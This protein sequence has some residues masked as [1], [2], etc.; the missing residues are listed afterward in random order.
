MKLPEAVATLVAGHSLKALQCAQ[1]FEELLDPAT[2]DA[3]IAAFLRALRAKGE[4][5]DEIAGAAKTMLARALPVDLGAGDELLDTC[6]TGGDRIGTFNISTGAALIAAAAGVKVAKHGNRAASGRVG[7]ADVLEAL[8]VKL[9]PPIEGLRRC[10]ERAGICFLFAPKFHP[11][12][13]RLAPIRRAIGVR[14]IFNLL[15]PLCNPAQAGRRLIGVADKS[16]ARPVAEAALALDLKHLLVIH[17]DDGLDEISSNAQTTLISVRNGRLS[18]TRL[19]PRSVGIAPGRP[20]EIVISSLNQ[21]VSMLRESL[22]SQGGGAHDV[23]ALN[24]GAA[25]YV[26]GRADSI[27]EGISLARDVL[28]EGRALATLEALRS[29]SRGGCIEFDT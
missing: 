19:D 21:A 5:A 13:V 2:S 12:L 18:E 28:R 17:S 3:N 20:N 25:I 15:G 1:A 27:E 7:G 24:G 23:L 29:Q 11:A 16:L 22:A 8:G 6:G 9:D 26:G 14:T 4:N 10:L